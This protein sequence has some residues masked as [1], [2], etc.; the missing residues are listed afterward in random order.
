MIHRFFNFLRQSLLTVL[1]VVL[2]TLLAAGGWYLYQ[3]H[4]L[5]KS[6]TYAMPVS[7][8]YDTIHT[9]PTTLPTV[10]CLRPT[11]MP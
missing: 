10:N 6:V 9:R 7:T 8:L 3:G 11:S 5:Y 2:L 1:L 4:R